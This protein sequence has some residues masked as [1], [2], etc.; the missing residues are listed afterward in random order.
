VVLLVSAIL[1]S[2]VSIRVLST[3]DRSGRKVGRVES[4]TRVFVG[5]GTNVL[6]VVAVNWATSLAG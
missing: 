2:V 1:A 3:D 4:M 5:A 6:S